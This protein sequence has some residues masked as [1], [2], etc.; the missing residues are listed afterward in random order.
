MGGDLQMNLFVWIEILKASKVHGW[1]IP[2]LTKAVSSS[3]K[4]YLSVNTRLAAGL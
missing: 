4:S 3:M 2:D 1:Y